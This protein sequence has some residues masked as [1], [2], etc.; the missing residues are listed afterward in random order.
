[1]SWCMNRGPSF[2]SVL[3]D[4]KKLNGFYQRFELRQDDN[5]M[6]PGKR[7]PH[8]PAE[9]MKGTFKL[10]K[11]TRKPK[12]NVVKP[13]DNIP[14]NQ[15]IPIYSGFGNIKGPSSQGIKKQG[16]KLKKR[17]VRQ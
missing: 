9:T 8:L 2:I 10:K 1:M 6:T 17:W 11:S 3:T 15:P 14:K 12:K 4:R 7:Q 5:R 13:A 16:G